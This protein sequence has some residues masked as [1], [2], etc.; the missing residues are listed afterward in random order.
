MGSPQQNYT[1]SGK[2]AVRACM[3]DP[4]GSDLRRLKSDP[5]SE[6][7]CGQAANTDGGTLVH[8]TCP[9]ELLFFLA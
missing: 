8:I 7:V 4:G 5:Y 6:I 3:P 1:R 2:A 9:L